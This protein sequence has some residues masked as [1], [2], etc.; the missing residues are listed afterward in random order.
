MKYFANLFG[1]YFSDFWMRKKRA[2][3]GGVLVLAAIILAAFY[4]IYSLG[5]VSS[6]ATAK[7]GIFDVKPGDGFNRIVDGLR[8]RG[9]IR[10]G[11]AF[12]VFSLIT[13]SA[14]KLKPGRY[15]LNT[16]LASQEILREI[17]SGLHREVVVTIP[18]GAS[19]YEIDDILSDAG[20]ISRGSLIDFGAPGKLEGRLF[21]DTYRFFT[22]SET[23]DAIRRLTEN[24]E[25]KTMPLFSGDGAHLSDNLILASL[26]EKEVPDFPSKRVVA[27]IIKKRLQSGLQ[28][29]VDAAICYIK[30]GINRA[31]SCYPLTPLDFKID[32]PYNTYSHYGLPPAPIGNPGTSSIMA[33]LDPQNTPYW[34]YLSDPKTGKTIFSKTYEEHL[35]NK[36]IYLKSR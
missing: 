4:L 11:L 27:G 32:S 2:I 14:G 15:E 29:Q 30:K 1:D 9:F 34:F 33:A 3:A 10:S 7:R 13:G 22:D 25:A 36:I 31:G 23:G 26:I 24:F 16:G 20:V 12:K 28:L 21:P 18:E 19:V 8:E 35:K 5:P 6:A 17:I